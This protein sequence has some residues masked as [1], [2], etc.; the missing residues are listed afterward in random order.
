MQLELVFRNRHWLDSPSDAVLIRG[1]AVRLSLVRNR[2]ARRYILRLSPDGAA[3]V[4]IPRGGSAVEA[5]Q[6]VQKNISWIESQLLRQ[7]SRPVSPKTWLSGTK[8]LFRGELVALRF[9]MDSSD[10]RVY[11]G[12]EVLQI[13]DL[14]ADLRP[15]VERH[16]W[17]LAMNELTARVAELAVV[18][19]L[20]VRRVSVRN[21]R[22]RWGSC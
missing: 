13:K 12:N 15:A 2:R 1:R 14:N 16:L 11:L 6:F 8:I 20:T 18:H 17:K 4:T 22:S 19:Q 5:R 21:Q 9:E 10:A 3:R 7:A